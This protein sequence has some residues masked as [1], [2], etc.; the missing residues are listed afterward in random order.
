METILCL[1]GLHK[2]DSE[3]DRY[4]SN[5][6]VRCGHCRTEEGGG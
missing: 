1:L 3:P 5:R 4:Y 6:C 2:Y